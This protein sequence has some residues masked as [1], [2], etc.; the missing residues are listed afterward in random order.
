M[1]DQPKRR[2]TIVGS[3]QDGEDPNFRTDTV[4]EIQSTDR[5]DGAR[6]PAKAK[7]P[8]NREV[9]NEMVKTPEHEGEP[10][11]SATEPRHSS[12]GV[13]NE[14]RR[15]PVAESVNIPDPKTPKHAD[16]EKIN[17]GTGPAPLGG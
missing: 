1:I 6:A 13:G 4:A 10:P 8:K 12:E 7:R 5:H 2:E 15:A 11:K 16:D 17:E 14:K 3:S 9:E